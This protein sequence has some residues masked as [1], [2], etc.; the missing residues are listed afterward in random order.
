MRTHY[1]TTLLNPAVLLLG[2]ALLASPVAYAEGTPDGETPAEED[3]CTKWGFTGKVQGLCKAFCEA[4]DCDSSTPQAS[5][6]ACGRVLDN[7]MGALGDTPFPTCQDVDGDGVP[8]G[9]DNCVDFPNPGQ[10][11]ADGNGVGDEC[12]SVPCPCEGLSHQNPDQLTDPVTWG[13][14]FQTSNCWK[15]LVPPGQDIL[16]LSQG[17][18]PHNPGPNDTGA[19]RLTVTLART[20][21]AACIVEWAGQTRNEG[22]GPNAPCELIVPLSLE[23]ADACVDSLEAIALEDGVDVSAVVAP[24]RCI[25]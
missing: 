24:T 3:I 17:I 11:D 8:N 18:D 4:M 23:E 5:E 19:G 20:F 14:V 21:P 25:P 12:D 10:E 13:S 2:L 22:C 1:L 7:I 9:L 6:R 15:G 16:T